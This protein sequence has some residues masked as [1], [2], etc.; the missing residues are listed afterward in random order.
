M[1]KGEL[2]YEGKAK[3]VYLTYDPDEALVRFKDDATA[4][5]GEKRGTI[6]SK[7]VMNSAITSFFFKL[8]ETKGIPTHFIEKVDERSMRVKKLAIIP[9]EVVV[10]NVSAGSLAQRLGWEEG[11]KL[12]QPVVELYYK[13]DALG[14]PLIN[15]SHVAVLGAATPEQ[16]NVMED[17]ALKVNS[18]LT[19]FLATKNLL[20]VDFKLEFGV[21]KGQVLLGDEISPDTCR[22]WDATTNK[23]LDKDRFRRDLGDVE[24]AYQEVLK[25]IGG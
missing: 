23:K 24:G 21:H 25:R 12:S 16:L 11:R 7:G 1:E 13:D 20:L 15:R 19:E 14:D 10:R 9:I 3:Q 22:F 2:V 8:L 6:Q 4:F 18:I 5:N 17:W